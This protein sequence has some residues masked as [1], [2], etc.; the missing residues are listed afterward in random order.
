MIKLLKF[1]KNY[2]M[3]KLS[4]IFQEILKFLLIFLF[5]FIWLRYLT[6]RFLSSLIFSLILSSVI[7]L[8]LK[9]IKTKRHKVLDLKIKE[10]ED[11]ENMFISLCLQDDPMKFF[12]HLAKTKHENVTTKKEYLIINNPE[13]VKTILY[14]DLTMSGMTIPHFMEIYSKIK[15]EKATKIVICCKEISDKMV[16]SFAENFKEKFLILDQYETYKNLYKFYGV[17]PEITNKKASGKKMIIKD[18][19]AFSFNKKRTKGYLFSALVLIIS[20]LFIP[21]TI[22]YCI[23]ASILVVFALISQFNPVYNQSKSEEII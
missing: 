21:T 4:L 12:E 6:K 22:Y 17:Y 11:S 10:K 9:L 19:L 13:K 3:R 14:P 8:F 1:V 18:F 2:D 16:F 7:F 23:V 20:G 5:L 15:K